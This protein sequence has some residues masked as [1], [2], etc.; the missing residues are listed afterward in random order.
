[1]MIRLLRQFSESKTNPTMFLGS[2][3][4]GKREHECFL[5]VAEKQHSPLLQVFICLLIFSGKWRRS[6]R[7]TGSE[8]TKEKMGSIWWHLSLA[9]EG[10]S[11]SVLKML[12]G[13]EH[14]YCTGGQKNVLPWDPSNL[15][16]SGH[17]ESPYFC[18]NRTAAS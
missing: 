8:K 11:K 6:S 2:C 17:T 1:M 9:S 3:L 13:S 18:R 16:G 5:M 4:G 7:L 15:T 14:K 10:G 12:W